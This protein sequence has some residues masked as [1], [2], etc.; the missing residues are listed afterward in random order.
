[1]TRGTT[2]S[3]LQVEL[4]SDATFSR[5]E[6]T[7][8]L[9]D[10]EV[11][12]DVRGLPFISGRTVRGLL[13]DSWLSMHACFPDLADAA[14]RVL[15]PSKS[16]DEGCRLRVGDA[17]LPSPIR[18]AAFRGI[19]RQ[20]HPLGPETILAAFSEIR[21]QTAEDRR[22]GA[23]ERTTLRSTRVVLRGFAFEANLTW[24]DGYQPARDDL[25]V[26]ALS[27]LATRHGGLARNRGRGHLRCTIEGD[28][29]HTRSL[30]EGP[31]TR[32]PS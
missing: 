9:V 22:R 6:G 20:E 18:E 5:G 16:L 4:L 29:G 8:G 10:V 3:R 30:A 2:P 11:E 25:Q 13:R 26:L 24:L 19:E 15:G 23:P 27:A 14:A 28:L 17:L 31:S 7:A 1:M 12:H 32:R 21:Y